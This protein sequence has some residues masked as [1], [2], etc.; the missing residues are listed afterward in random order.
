[1]YQLFN[2]DVL[3]KEKSKEPISGGAEL[4]KYQYGVEK[5]LH[6]MKWS[7]PHIMHCVQ[8]LLQFITEALGAHVQ[9]MNWTIGL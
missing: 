1:M 4:T 3:R 2:I 9:A 5:L 8:E 7:Q 6:L